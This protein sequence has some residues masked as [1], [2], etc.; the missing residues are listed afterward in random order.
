MRP[1]EVAREVRVSRQSGTVW[2]HAWQEEGIGGRRQ[3]ERAGRPALLS[4]KELS[5]VQRAL[6]KGPA[7]Y[8]WHTEPW[9]LER[10]ADVIA[11]ET[12]IRYHIGHVWKILRRLAWSWQKP[13]RRAVERDEEEIE[14]WVREEWPE[15]KNSLAGSRPGSSSRMRA[16]PR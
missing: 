1:A 4:K 10:V 6:L 12:G 7:A 14:R 15:I 13:A 8:G 2:R 16:E 3:A 9:T 5:K 11:M